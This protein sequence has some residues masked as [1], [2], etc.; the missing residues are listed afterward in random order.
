MGK[1]ANRLE[2]VGDRLRA[3][4]DEVVDDATRRVQASVQQSAR[5]DFGPDLRLS[6]LGRNAT[7]QRVTVT[8]R[9]IGQS[10]IGHVMAGPPRQRAAWFWMDEGTKAGP[11]RRRRSG[12]IYQHPGTPAKRTW[13][14][15]VEEVLPRVQADIETRFRAIIRG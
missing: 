5:A 11:R 15:P 10:A 13:S 9:S 6:G 1:A 3:L 2:R 12:T 14:D 7:R 8:K 4:P